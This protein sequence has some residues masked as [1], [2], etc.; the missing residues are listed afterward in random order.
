MAKVLE[1]TNLK[2]Q[3]KEGPVILSLPEVRQTISG[4]LTPPEIYQVFLCSDLASLKLLTCIL[5]V[6]NDIQETDA[7]INCEAKTYIM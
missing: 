3:P 4:Y 5:A 7:K 1:Y 2:P 6:T